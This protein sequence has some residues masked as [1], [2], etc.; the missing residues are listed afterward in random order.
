MFLWSFGDGSADW[1]GF[2][3]TFELNANHNYLR[4]KEFVIADRKEWTRAVDRN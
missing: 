2:E 1:S 3:P 4:I